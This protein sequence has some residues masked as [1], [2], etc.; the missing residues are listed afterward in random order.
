MLRSNS[1]SLGNHV[2]ILK[3]KRKG[4]NGKEW[5]KRKIFK[6]G[7]KELVYALFMI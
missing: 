5:Q 6:P 3:E 1:K 2:V 7:M 4:C